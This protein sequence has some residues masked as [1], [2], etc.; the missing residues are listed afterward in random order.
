MPA[1]VRS[2]RWAALIALGLAYALLAHHTNTTPQSGTLGSAL[3]VAPLAAGALTLAWH[4]PRRRAMLLACALGFTASWLAWR[5]AQPHFSMLY[6]VEHAG[7][8]LLLGVGFART[9]ASGQEPMCTRFARMIQGQL[10][11]AIERYTRR[12]TWA[13]ALFFGLMAATSTLL[14]YAAPLAAWSMFAN[15]FT[16]PLICLMF[17][18]EYALR[19]LLFPHMEH[20]PILAAVRAFWSPPQDRM[21]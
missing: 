20:A 18:A 16:G 2:W 6:W 10:T 7:T 8:E 4:S 12:I 9:L 1:A 5:S 11:P 3:A 19:R 13:W 15:F 14:Y 17:V 21:P